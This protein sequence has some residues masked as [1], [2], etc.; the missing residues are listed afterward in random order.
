MQEWSSETRQSVSDYGA[1][2]S[3]IADAGI[4]QADFSFELQI[5]GMKPLIPEFQKKI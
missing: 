1:I 5:R 4:N 2:Q 3:A